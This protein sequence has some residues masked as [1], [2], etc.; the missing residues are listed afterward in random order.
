VISGL[1]ERKKLATRA[2]LHSAALRLGVER[3][4]EHVTVE[5]IAAAAD[6]SPRTFFNYFSSK[7]EAFVAD[8]LERGRRFVDAVAS[9]PEDLEP[10]SLLHATA[11]EVLGA[12]DVPA[13][14]QALKEQ[15][16]R[17]S[18]AVVAQVLE[19]FTRLEDQLVTELRRRSPSSSAL[20]SRLMAGAVMAVA[21]AAAR[22]WMDASDETSFAAVLDDAFL[23]LS[24]A[25]APTRR[26]VRATR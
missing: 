8:D 15:L 17:E 22:T 9:A 2:A 10:W 4:V 12:S 16:V 1:R 21:R 13:R 24:P 5:D 6:V 3:G 25:F 26:P 14:E 18:P 7:E 11:V 19:T 23:A 20:Q